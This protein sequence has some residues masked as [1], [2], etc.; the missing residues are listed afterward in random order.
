MFKYL[1]SKIKK[2]R[3]TSQISCLMLDNRTMNI[4]KNINISTAIE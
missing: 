3:A 1:N 2:K 4:Y